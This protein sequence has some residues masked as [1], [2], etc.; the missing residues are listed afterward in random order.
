MG[1]DCC[2]LQFTAYEVMQAEHLHQ[3][4]ITI[5]TLISI[6]LQSVQTVVWTASLV[7]CNQVVVLITMCGNKGSRNLCLHP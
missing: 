1:V 2:I 7:G 6:R 4:F 3:G 5:S